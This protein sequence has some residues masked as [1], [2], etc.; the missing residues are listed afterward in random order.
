[1]GSIK[2]ANGSDCMFGMEGGGKAFGTAE[3][4]TM[5]KGMSIDNMFG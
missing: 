4:I 5:C 2:F 3:E 1:M